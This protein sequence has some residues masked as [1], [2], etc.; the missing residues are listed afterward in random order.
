MLLHVSK[1]M[2]KMLAKCRIMKTDKTFWVLLAILISGAVLRIYDLGT[3]SLWFDEVGSVDL[4]MRDVGS[5]FFKFHNSPF[6]FL[7]LK[8]WMSIWGVSESALRSLSVIFGISSVFLI[9]KVSELLFNKKVAL[10]SAFL[11]SISPVHIFYSQEAR[12]YSLLVFMTLLSMFIFIRLLRED[13]IKLYIYYVLANILLCYTLLHGVLVLV[14]QNIFFFLKGKNKKRW[15]IAQV[16]V[17]IFFLAWFIPVIIVSLRE[18]WIKVS[19]SWIPK[20]NLGTLLET[21]RTFSYG[22]ESYGGADFHISPKDL[23][24]PKYLFYIFAILSFLGLFYQVRPA[25]NAKEFKPQP[26]AALLL[27]LWLFLSILIPYVFSRSFLSLYVIRYVTFA[28]PAFLIIIAVGLS[29]IERA[30]IRS[31]IILAI[32]I[33]TAPAL[34][35]YYVKDLKIGWRQTCSFI[36]ENM[37]K[38]DVIIVSLAKQIRIFG[39][40]GKNGLR[41]QKKSSLNIDKSLGSALVTGG[42]VYAD[43]VYKLIGVND[44]EQLIQ[45]VN[46]S[47][48]ISKN[49]NVW[50]VLTRWAVEIGSAEPI[51]KYIDGF[52]QSKQQRHYTGVSVYHYIPYE[53]K[54]DI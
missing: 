27:S 44:V 36:N 11:L 47:G 41:Y 3:E 4:A 8:Y 34:H 35:T 13:K 54:Q 21:F 32:I 6:Y 24:L 5:F 46:S 17:L 7:I 1:T 9:Y 43:E 15:I 49:S 51:R 30:T 26:G 52:Y 23:L 42:F 20:P 25:S 37:K 12:N 16:V 18:P 31:G 22:G 45:I 50:L 10:F 53:F 39:Y 2:V 29:K 38:D 19:T 14:G 48:A 28:L 40:Y 33:M